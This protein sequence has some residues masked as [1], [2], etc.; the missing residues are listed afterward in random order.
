MADK[1]VQLHDA[2]GNNLFPASAPV[3]PNT[4]VGA[5]TASS[6][7]AIGTALSATITVPAGTYELIATLP[8]VSANTGAFSI[9][10]GNGSAVN[11]R[12]I[13]SVKQGDTI[14]TVVTVVENTSYYMAWEASA[15]CNFTHL[16]RGGLQAVRLGGSNSALIDASL[17]LSVVN[18]GTGVSSLN[19]LL[20]SFITTYYATSSNTAENSWAGFEETKT[21]HGNGF[22]LISISVITDDTSS[23]G[24]TGAVIV[25]GGNT[26]AADIKRY[27]SAYAQKQASSATIMRAFS[28]GDTFKVGMGSTRGGTKWY[29]RHYV[30]FGCTLT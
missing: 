19:A 20:N 28:D 2:D 10:D 6:A 25:V 18:G 15:S 14:T 30:A 13:A 22:V 21:V 7:S 4:Y 8:D 29:R 24:T 26:V 11:N 5:F 9:R 3:T 1:F 27:P 16:E 12:Y 23:Y 17:P